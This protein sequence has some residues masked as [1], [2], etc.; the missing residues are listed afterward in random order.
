MIRNKPM[1]LSPNSLTNRNPE[2]GQSIAE[3]SVALP[4][5]LL[6]VFAL[7][8]MGILFA[9]YLS[10]VNAAREG[11]IFASKYAALIDSTCG[12]SPN[13]TCVGSGDNNTYSGSQSIW[14]EYQTRISNDLFVAIGEQLKQG[15]L[16]D[17]DT[18]TV[19]RP[20]ANATC[21]TAIGCPVTVTVSYRIHTFTS[22]IS[23]PY[24]GRFGL[25]NYYQITYTVGM[26][27]H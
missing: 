20:I 11:A 16:V 3:I 8:E 26:P 21:G 13:P 5:L 25:P 27:I 18:L 22:D 15:Q 7:V 24:F 19:Y 17:Q 4:F 14:E 12:S 6:I 23:M 1:R 2:R 10:E 9:S